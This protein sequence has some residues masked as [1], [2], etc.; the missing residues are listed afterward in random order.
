[1]ANIIDITA[2]GVGHNSGSPSP[3]SICEDRICELNRKL[4]RA[5]SSSLRIAIELGCEMEEAKKHFASADDFIKWMKERA[6]IGRRQVYYLLKLAELDEA[7]L[8]AL[9]WADQSPDLGDPKWFYID[10]APTLLLAAHAKA[11]GA[12]LPS[13]APTAASAPK[14][15]AAV[16]RYRRTAVVL[17]SE[18]E[19][20]WAKLAKLGDKPLPVSPEVAAALAVAKEAAERN[21]ADA[22]RQKVEHKPEAPPAQAAGRRKP[23]AAVRPASGAVSG[24]RSGERREG[25]GRGGRKGSD[26]AVKRQATTALLKAGLAGARA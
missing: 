5:S 21:A 17:A 13:S 6:G 19:M 14:T 11:T 3:L 8:A 15:E 26:P 4:L 12:S 20:L 18:V 7:L 1:M 16:V 2:P 24:D 25:A 9:D 10:K 23:Q 22:A